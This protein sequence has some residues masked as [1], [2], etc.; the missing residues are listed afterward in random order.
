MKN[1]IDK[2]DGMMKIKGKCG[3]EIIGGCSEL[4]RLKQE[5]EK[6]KEE[7]AVLQAYKDVNENFKKVW[8]EMRTNADKVYNK[9][10]DYRT[11]LEEINKLLDKAYQTGRKNLILAK[12]RDKINEVLNDKK[13]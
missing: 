6:L 5:N 9:M 11:A 2:L 13:L 3:Y 7:N 8:D 4:R 12:I 10:L 1:E